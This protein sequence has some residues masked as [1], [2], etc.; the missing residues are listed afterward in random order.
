MPESLPD[1]TIELLNRARAGEAAA[2][3]RLFARYAPVLSRWAHRRLPLAARDLNET[4][5]LVQVT[6]MRAFGRLEAFE[7]RGP[8]AF[9]GYLRHILLNVIRNEL[10]RVSSR[11]Q[12]AELSDSLPQA[13]PSVVEQVAG[14]EVLARYER[15]LEALNPE[16]REA[17]ILRVELH[18]PFAEIAELLQKPSENAA[19]MAVSRA[20]VSLAEAMKEPK[21]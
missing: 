16:A 14:R 3:N 6:L 5:D 2:R 19:R 12:H 10:R 21:P 17:V 15:G 9:L 13:G 7:Y 4:Q 8:G 1:T 20:L 18:L 11:P